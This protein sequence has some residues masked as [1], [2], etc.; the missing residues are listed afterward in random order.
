MTITLRLSSAV[1]YWSLLCFKNVWHL[2]ATCVR[3]P[4]GL[5]NKAFVP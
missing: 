3:I 4:D 1:S 5:A 2:H